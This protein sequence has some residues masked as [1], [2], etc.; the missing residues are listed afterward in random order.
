M[1]AN[2]YDPLLPRLA[3][4]A[5]ISPGS[6]GIG[7]FAG[8]CRFPVVTGLGANR[9]DRTPRTTTLQRSGSFR[10]LRR[11]RDGTHA[12]AAMFRFHKKPLGPF[13]DAPS[14]QRWI[15]SLPV[16]DPLAVQRELLLELN[17]LA[18][19]TARRT[20]S[21]L[22]A[23]FIVDTKTNRV[24]RTLMAQYSE[25][26]NR[27]SKI[28]NQLWHALF[29]VTQGF[30]TC[31]AAF[32]REIADH[33]QNSKWQVLLPELIA[34]QLAHLGHDAKIRLYRCEQ[35]IPAKW[36]E[37]HAAFTRACALKLE[38]Q[39]IVLNAKRGATTIEREYLAVL[40]LLLAD[41]GNL[42]PKQ[43]EWVAAQLHE[44]CQ[45][46]RLTIEARAASTFY[47]DLAGSAGLRRR[48]LGPLD[49][50]ILFVDTRP[51]HAQLV[52]KRAELEKA[53]KTDP[54]SEK[55]PRQRAQ[56][57]LFETIASRIDPEFKPVARRGDRTPA[58]GTVDAIIGFNNITG[59]LRDDSPAPTAE[60][61]SGRSFANTMDLAVF[62]RTRTEP[63]TRFEYAR[64]RLA[65]FSASGGPWEMKDMSAS[66]F[67]LHAP[68]SVATE[69]TL[70]MLVA[71]N[72][73]GQNAWVM[74]IVR[75]MRRLSADRAD[76]GL[77]LIANAL[78]SADLVLQRKADD[79]DYSVD[80]EQAALAGRRFRGLF[81]SFEKR[82]GD[83]PVQSLIVPPVEYQPA[84]RYMLQMPGSARP[85]RYGRVL[86]QHSDWLWTV[87]E[88][89]EHDDAAAGDAPDA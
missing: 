88:P 54:R 73:G 9:I 20:P 51:L 11:P 31:Y 19:R 66:G 60:F 71:I 16:N 43:V 61:D 6:V 76:I 83:P 38:R 85:I 5:M 1:H 84:R 34:R 78:I 23:V 70:S 65:A 67:R 79:A 49:G 22:A 56:L 77:Q 37:L 10:K 12:T 63:D 69:V 40:L 64:R 24:V 45:P 21:G 32:A 42:M 18:E 74:G 48:A 8:S 80:G 3:L 50:R 58:S 14:V 28:E 87:V 27:S 72:R 89:L 30:Q 57:D 36:A 2:R 75:R 44:W 25:H 17:R 35:W 7:M 59:F 15:A 41:P 62:G 33:A 39:P 13:D 81:L 86:E 53:A 55:A 47:V 82:A 46:L 52:Q 4:C 68:M 29:D 26:A